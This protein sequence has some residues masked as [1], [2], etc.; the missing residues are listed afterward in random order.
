ML[1]AGCPPDWEVDL[2]RL[3]DPPSLL[4]RQPHVMLL[5]FI[6]WSSTRLLP[7]VSRFGPGGRCCDGSSRGGHVAGGDGEK[8]SHPTASSLEEGGGKKSKRAKGE[9]RLAKYCVSLSSTAGSSTRSNRQGC[10]PT[11]RRRECP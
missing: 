1:V 3:K 7:R 5:F 6:R 9:E 8:N 4:Y 11:S 2:R 10:P